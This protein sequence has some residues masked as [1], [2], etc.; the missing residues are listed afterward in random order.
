MIPN[1]IC[2]LHSVNIIYSTIIEGIIKGD[3]L[4]IFLPVYLL[5]QGPLHSVGKLLR[6]RVHVRQ[7]G[8]ESGGGEQVIVC[9][10]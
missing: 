4:Y 1:T 3:I 10:F 7:D 9:K 5:C 2:Q 6:N 8:S